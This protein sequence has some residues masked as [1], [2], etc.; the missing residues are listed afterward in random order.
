MSKSAGN[1]R[2]IYVYHPKERYNL[3]FI[4]HGPGKLSDECKSLRN[5]GSKYA[6]SRH[7]KVHCLEPTTKKIFGRHQG[8][9]DIVK[10]VVDEIILHDNIRIMRNMKYMRT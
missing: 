4:I 5:F 10:H 3:I 6:K 8:N 7:T 9:N 1:G 2:K